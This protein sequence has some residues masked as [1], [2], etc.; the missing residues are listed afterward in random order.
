MLTSDLKGAAIRSRKPEQL[1]K[2]A[3]VELNGTP[4]SAQIT[5]RLRFKTSHCVIFNTHA[6]C[7]RRFSERSG[8]SIFSPPLKLLN[9]NGVDEPSRVTAFAC[10]KSFKTKVRLDQ[11]GR[12][13]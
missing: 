1:M 7:A 6:G 11:C 13:A 5:I 10:L 3:V 4:V 2:Q 12:I 8:K 9:F